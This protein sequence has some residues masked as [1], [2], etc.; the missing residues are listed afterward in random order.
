VYPQLAG[1]ASADV[2]NAL[3]G[4][5]ETKI[6]LEHL[7]YRPLIVILGSGLALLLLRALVR[8]PAVTPAPAEAP[9]ATHPAL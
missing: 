3:F 9:V 7:S 2:R 8:N 6:S 5:F 4:D 1:K